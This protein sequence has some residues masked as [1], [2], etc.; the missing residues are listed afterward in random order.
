MKKTV[1]NRWVGMIPALNFH[2]W[3]PCNMRCR[4]CFAQFDRD[5]RRAVGLSYPQCKT[6]IEYAAQA[7]VTKITFAGGEPLLSPWLPSALRLSKAFGMTTMIVTNGLLLCSRWLNEHASYVDWIG[8]SVDSLNVATNHKIGRKLCSGQTLLE[9]DCLALASEIQTHGIRLKI[10][11]TVTKHNWSESLVDFIRQVTP[12]RWKIFQVLCIKGQ[13][14]IDFSA[15]AVTRNQFESYLRRHETVRSITD[16]V[17]EDNSAMRGSYLMVD[18]FGRFY[19]NCEAS[20]RYSE[21][22]WQVGWERALSQVEVST[23]QFLKREGYYY[24]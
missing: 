8:L 11:T 22:I 17:A 14:D 2:F 9:K 19:D 15:I 5:E 20:Y 12:A 4:Y 7:G 24:W 1:E 23:S 3:Q 13:N 6:I 16:L 21:P 10:N 18:P